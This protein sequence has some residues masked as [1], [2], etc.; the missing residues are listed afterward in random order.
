M[1]TTLI[2]GA[3]R[4]LGKELAI[5]FHKGGY[6]YREDYQLILHSKESD[7]FFLT[8]FVYFI[9]IKSIILLGNLLGKER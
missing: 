9:I 7:I 2:T 3:G 1:K 6:S 4:G 5:E 8:F